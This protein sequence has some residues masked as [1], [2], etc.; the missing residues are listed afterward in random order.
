LML[1]N[2]ISCKVNTGACISSCSSK[3]FWF[4]VL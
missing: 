4:Y 3:M 1:R 2:L